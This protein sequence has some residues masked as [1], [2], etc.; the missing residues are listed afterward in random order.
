MSHAAT[1]VSWSRGV[2][3]C[4]LEAAPP[5][6]TCESGCVDQALTPGGSSLGASRQ[7]LQ[8]RLGLSSDASFPPTEGTMRRYLVLALAATVALTPRAS[9]RQEL[10][11]GQRIRIRTSAVGARPLVGTLARHD[12][13]TLWLQRDSSLDSIPLAAIRALERSAGAEQTPAAPGLLS[14]VWLGGLAAVTYAG[15]QSQGCNSSLE[16]IGCGVL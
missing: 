13:T 3:G 5:Q 4:R 14:I 12:S 9:S 2:R 6:R 7:P 16:H 11:P 15:S 10:A 1:T 8:P